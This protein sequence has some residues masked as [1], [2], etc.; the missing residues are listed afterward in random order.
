M[1]HALDLRQSC[2]AVADHFADIRNMVDIGSGVQAEQKKLA[3]GSA[4]AEK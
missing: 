3:G 2:H 4:D 1:S